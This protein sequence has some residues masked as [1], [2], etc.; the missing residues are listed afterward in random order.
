VFHR[1]I[2]RPGN[3][4]QG[5]TKIQKDHKSAQEQ[6]NKAG[7][8]FD[9]GHEG[10]DLAEKLHESAAKQLDMGQSCRL[11]DVAFV[12]AY[13]DWRHDGAHREE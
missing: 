2:L 6:L 8:C 11:G 13:R 7:Q 1:R 12:S 9:L 10:R 5:V 4:K 3:L